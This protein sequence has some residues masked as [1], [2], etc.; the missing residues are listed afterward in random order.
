MGSSIFT[1][2]SCA[3]G[4]RN[5]ATGLAENGCLFLSK[6]SS[7][8]RYLPK[9]DNNPYMVANPKPRGWWG[10]H[11]HGLQPRSRGQQPCQFIYAP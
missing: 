1:R 9:H 8:F 3:Y 7:L 11:R 2:M 4:L 6:A 10:I 5:H